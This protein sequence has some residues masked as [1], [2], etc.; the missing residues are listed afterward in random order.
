MVEEM[1]KRKI[2]G[3]EWKGRNEYGMKGVERRW[4]ASSSFL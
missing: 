3:G 2:N 4:K 1:K